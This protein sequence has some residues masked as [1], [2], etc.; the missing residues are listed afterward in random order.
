MT[1]DKNPNKL[2][3]VAGLIA[4]LPYRDLEHL[5]MDV[6][7]ALAEE[8]GDNKRSWGWREVAEALLAASSRILGE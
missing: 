6:G 5:A 1:L 8:S 3:A 2:K 7:E 4:G